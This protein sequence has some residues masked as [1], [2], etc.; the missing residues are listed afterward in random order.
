MVEPL[1]DALARDRE[2]YV[3]SAVPL[4]ALAGGSVR[5]G[6]EGILRALRTDYLD[7]Y[8]PSHTISYWYLSKCRTAPL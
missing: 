2:R 5:R 1:R 3:V 7:V 8:M 6:A 4:F